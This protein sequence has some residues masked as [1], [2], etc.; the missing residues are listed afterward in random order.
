MASS[1]VE[2]YIKR[3]YLEQA[4]SPGELVPMGELAAAMEVAPGTATAMIKTLANAELADY[5]PRA[6]VRLTRC[7]EQ[8]ALHVL[9]RHRLVEQLL[10]DVL[11]LDWSEVHE[12]AEAL[13]HAISDRVLARIDELLGHPRVDPHGDPIPSPKGELPPREAQSLCDC[14]VG[15]PLCVS[16]V[17]DQAAGFLRMLDRVGLTPGTRIRVRERDASADAVTLCVSNGEA[18]TLGSQA[19]AKILVQPAT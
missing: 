12:E 4:R 13:E 16:R 9:R 6:G 2:N 15:K 11:G 7:G 5:E 19:A 14:P 1:T 17:L 3:I 8:L 10:V 18:I